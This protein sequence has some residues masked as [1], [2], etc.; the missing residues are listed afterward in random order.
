MVRSDLLF[1]LL[2]PLTQQLNVQLFYADELPAI[3][4]AADADGLLSM[5]NHVC[6]CPS[7]GAWW[8]HQI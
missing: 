2:K 3:E 6:Y 7:K 8:V 1:E 5:V 4:E